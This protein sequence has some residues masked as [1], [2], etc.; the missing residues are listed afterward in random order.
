MT[1]ASYLLRRFVY[2]IAVL[3]A[4]TFTVSIMMSLPAG[5][6][7]QVLAGVDATPAQIEAVREALKLDQPVL[8]RYG[9]WLSSAVTGD[10]GR[11]LRTGEPV[12]DTIR[13]RLPVTLQ[14]VVMGQ[15]LALAFAVPIAVYG[16]YRPGR[17]LD[18]GSTVL[19]FLMIST[20]PFVVG[21]LLIRI[22]AVDLGW[23]P[24]GG[25]TPLT[26]D[27]AASLR[28]ALLPA[29]AI[30]LEP[31]GVYQRL[32]RSDMRRT[33]GE[34]F[35]MM[36]ESKGLRPRRV[37]FRH[38]LRPSSFSLLTLMG[39][40]SARM[41]GGAVVVETIFGLPGL[42]RMLIDAVNFRDFIAVQGVVAVVAI[43]YVVINSIVDLTY[44]VVDPRVRT[45]AS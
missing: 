1:M 10:L 34:D 17:L 35:I 30:A 45:H 2:L 9:D 3:L 12:I 33:L 42:G 14:L 29:V 40:I 25:W 13:D 41:V 22:F 39:I 32:L 24:T 16:S 27:P 18:S 44:G 23:F 36:A 6:P 11:S 28:A 20:P 15:L 38:S 26:A 8:Q 19:S 43:A 31:A 5:D 21:L 7:A 4:V 37:L